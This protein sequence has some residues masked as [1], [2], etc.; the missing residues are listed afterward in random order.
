M[1]TT[2][3]ENTTETATPEPTSSNA[4]AAKYRKQLREVEAERDALRS[5]VTGMQRGEVGRL[6]DAEGIKADALWS[7][8]AELPALLTEDG[9]VDGDKVAAAINA[10]REMFG[11]TQPTPAVPDTMGMGNVGTPIK[12]ERE[13]SWND[14][15]GSA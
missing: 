13:P 3:E 10:T 8:G 15:I 4:E 7:S 5:T 12:V 14:L 1:T 9:L 6:A 2:P 11:I